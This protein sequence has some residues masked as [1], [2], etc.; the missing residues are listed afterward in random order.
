GATAF[1]TGL[2]LI[3][4]HLERHQTEVA[5][6]KLKELEARAADQF[7]P[8]QWYEFKALRSRIH[9][10]RWEWERAGRELL[11][12]KRH[13]PNTERARVNEALGYELVGEK[14]KAHALA[15]ALRTEFPHSVR[16]LT[17]WV[18]TAPETE[19][20]DALVAAAG[21][22]AKDNEELNLALAHRALFESR[23]E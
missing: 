11:D 9:S 6:A 7:K 5:E 3:K 17:V 19:R 20:L 15:T 4:A 10:G 12:A 14:E 2:A 1:D 16:L 18:R 23:F 22:Y 13:M 8:H 21:P